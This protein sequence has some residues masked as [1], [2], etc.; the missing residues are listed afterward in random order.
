MVYVGHSKFRWWPM[1]RVLRAIEPV[2]DRVGR[3]GLVGHGWDAPPP[4]AASMQI[5]DLYYSDPAYLGK[6]GVEFI[7]PVPFKEVIP[8]MSRA[9]FNP[10]IYRP[11]FSHLRLVTCRTFETPASG[12]IPLFALAEQYVADLYGESAVELVL[13]KDRPEQKISDIVRRPDEYADV[14]VSIRR[15]LASKHSYHA[16]FQELLTLVQS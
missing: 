10:V 7:A 4:W 16:R 3:I 6:M 14:V 1:E 9:I 5:E 12:T 15:H 2:R 11:L 13:P 8:W